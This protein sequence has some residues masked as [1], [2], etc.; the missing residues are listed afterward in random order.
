MRR[1]TTPTHTFTLPDEVEVR[2]IV[3]AKAIYSQVGKT[4]LTKNLDNFSVDESENKLSCT[5]T[6]DETKLFA[7]EEAL[8]QLRI[9]VSNG[10][11]LASQ[12]L[13][14]TV[15]PVLNSEDM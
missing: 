5:L 7:P 3:E 14:L 11:V 6:Q 4:I 9:K 1:A 10:A 13:W 12:M 15:K 8:I 2:T